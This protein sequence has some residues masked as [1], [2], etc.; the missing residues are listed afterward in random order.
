[1][2]ALHDD[3]GINATGFDPAQEG[4]RIMVTF[5]GTVVHA[6]RARSV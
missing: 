5:T 4:D 6:T 1:M 2:Q 3:L